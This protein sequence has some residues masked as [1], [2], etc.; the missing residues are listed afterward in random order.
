M[1]LLAPLPLS[2]ARSPDNS[3]H[4]R[5]PNADFSGLAI[6]PRPAYAVRRF[7][8]PS[9][10]PTMRTLLSVFAMTAAATL[11]TSAALKPKTGP[12]FEDT[13]FGTAPEIPNPNDKTKPIRPE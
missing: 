8:S 2:L 13:P 5:Q 12:A 7:P 3:R 4:N 11:V 9:D 1:A 10:S 6:S